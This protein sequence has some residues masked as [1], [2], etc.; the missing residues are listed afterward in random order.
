LLV[1]WLNKNGHTAYCI[2][3]SPTEQEKIKAEEDIRYFREN[4]G[5]A[6]FLAMRPCLAGYR[7]LRDFVRDNKIDIIHAHREEA[8]RF[9]FFCRLLGA[10]R[11]P[12]VFQ[13]GTEY[14]IRKFSPSYFALKSGYVK[15]IIAVSQAVKNSLSRCGIDPAKVE[16]IYGGVDLERFSP[17]VSGAPI[18]ESIGLPPGAF[19]F[20]N[21]ASL[22]PKK[23]YDIFFRA[24]ARVCSEI[25]GAFFLV[26]GDGPFQKFSPLLDELGI[27]EKVAFLGFRRDIENVLAAL[28][29]LVCSSTKGEGLT[30]AIREGLAMKKPVVATDVAGNREFIIHDSTGLLVEPNNVDALAG[31]MV[32]SHN[33]Y[34]QMIELAEAGYQIVR[35]QADNNIRCKHIVDLYREAL[36]I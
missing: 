11:V 16:V 13:R 26:A 28:H 21:I 8:L 15:K 2:F 18:L 25:P 9:A 3:K 27:R 34:E 14:R 4:A 19:V 7:T 32:Q 33:A 24:A 22:A 20:G 10:F 12:L 35:K 17:D 1:A 36:G 31:A 30:G 5:E 29:V 23:G 6:F